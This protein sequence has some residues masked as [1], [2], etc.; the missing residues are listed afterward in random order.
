MILEGNQRS[1]AGH[2]ARHLLNTQDNDHVEVHEIS[3]FVSD[4]VQGAFQE[5]KASAYG[6]KCRQYMF[7]VSLNPP[8][9]A[10]VPVEVFEQAISDMG[11]RLGLKGQP[12][13]IVFHEKQGRRHA[14]C[15]WSRIDPQT[16]TAINLPH[17]KRKLNELSKELYLNHGW[18]I[19]QG[20]I[21][22]AYRNPLNFTREEWQQA[23][24]T[25]EDPRLL[26]ALFIRAWESSDSAKAFT[27]AL[28]EHGF[29]L[30]RGERR[31]FVAVDYKGEIYS[32]SRWAGV[33]PRILQER[34]GN[35]E[36]LPSLQEVRTEIAQGMSE[37]LQTYITE[38][39][40]KKEKDFKPIKHAAQT[41]RDHHRAARQ[42]LDN[43]QTKRRQEE[44][45]ARMERL[46]RGLFAL[47]QR[48]TGKYQ[49]ICKENE[50]EAQNALLRDRAEKQALILRQLEERQR[51]QSKIQQHRTAYYRSMQN[52]RLDMA[53]YGEMGESKIL[54]KHKSHT[55][56]II[57]D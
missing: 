20:F 34:L 39:K 8:H 36:T 2:L 18:E 27:H 33:K 32:L 41:M 48:F 31:G 43:E 37:K 14:H 10:D 54:Q 15:V 52:L 21:D 26:K 49:K 30:A 4:T 13:V 53:R 46:P 56:S 7:S 25:D 38:I 17:Y 57:E 44:D 22:K 11:D 55:V 47:W 42:T 12:R 50:I 40:R 1:G 9:K 5:I 35:A 24:R 51:L 29:W 45:K 19:P 28:K 16:M 23:K 6:T 3:G